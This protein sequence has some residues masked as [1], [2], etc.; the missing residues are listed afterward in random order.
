MGAVRFGY[1]ALGFIFLSLGII[2]YILPVMPG[3]V[4]IILSLWAFKKC[5]PKMEYWLLY[6]SPFRK[7]L[8]D[9]E[10]DHSISLRIKV[11]AISMI[12][13][14]ISGSIYTIHRKHGAVWVQ[15]MLFCIAI[16]LTIYLATRKTKV[17]AVAPLVQAESTP[18]A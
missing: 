6:Q 5:S 13:L 16:S 18:N 11:L 1:L 9:W 8:Q 2:G 10:L 17:V 7:V 14:T 4:F 3:T 15:V 12:W